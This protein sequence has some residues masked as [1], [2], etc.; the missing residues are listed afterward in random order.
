MLV[1][2]A[3]VVFFNS[4][5]FKDPVV[6]GDDDALILRHL[7]ITEKGPL[8]LVVES[9]QRF[10]EAVVLLE[11]GL[12]RVLQAAVAETRE[13]GFRKGCLRG[14]AIQ[15]LELENARLLL[16]REGE[17]QKRGEGKQYDLGWAFHR[18]SNLQK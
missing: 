8:Y 15:L 18:D 12:G 1:G 16:Y 5:W 6:G 13:I 11:V 10:A 7:G 3:L 4:P 2:M 9:G 17:Q 14:H